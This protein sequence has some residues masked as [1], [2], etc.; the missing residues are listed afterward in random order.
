MMERLRLDNAAYFIYTGQEDV[1][2]DVARVQVHPSVR[3]IKDWAFWECSGLTTVIL[4]DGLEEIGKRAFSRTSLVRINIPP[5]V[6]TIDVKAFKDCSQLTTITFCNKIEEL[7][8]GGLMRGWW[9][10]GVH[11]KCLS[12]YC[13]LV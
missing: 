5:A 7:V 9:N 1:P 8:S 13:L 12:T 11:E 4:G 6:R 10:N 2:K 3:A